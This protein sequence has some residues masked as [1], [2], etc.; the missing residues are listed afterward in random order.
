M[1]RIGLV[2]LVVALLG[3]VVYTIV[4]TKSEYA[5]GYYVGLLV[6]FGL[7][8]AVFR[9][10]G[11]WGCFGIVIRGIVVILGVLRI[12]ALIAHPPPS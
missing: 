9:F 1:A 5:I 8:V 7:I 10:A 3:Y 4:A 12:L 2:A 11:R 6:F